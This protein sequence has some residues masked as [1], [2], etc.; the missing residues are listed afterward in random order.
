MRHAIRAVR[1]WHVR[2]SY[3]G[4]VRMSGG[5]QKVKTAAMLEGL[6]AGSA[7]PFFLGGG[8]FKDPP[9]LCL[10]IFSA[11]L[12][13]KWCPAI[14]RRMTRRAWKTHHKNDRSLWR[15][16]GYRAFTSDARRGSIPS[17]TEGIWFLVNESCSIYLPGVLDTWRLINLKIEYLF[18]FFLGEGFSQILKILWNFMTKKHQIRI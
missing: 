6:A 9:L 3:D 10:K 17:Y 14:V 7:V 1:T 18:N 5:A 15:V 4:C 2:M 12:V 13:K 8:V 11:W 16:W